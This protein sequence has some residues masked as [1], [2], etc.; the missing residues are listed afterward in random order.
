MCNPIDPPAKEKSCIHLKRRF[1]MK[2]WIKALFLVAMV[3]SVVSAHAGIRCG[4]DLIAVGETSFEVQI[5]LESCGSVIA[6]KQ[7]G[8]S[9]ET[10]KKGD[11]DV[12]KERLVERWYIRVNERGGTYCY[13]LI[14]EQGL[15]NEI[16]N[17]RQC[18]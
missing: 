9:T 3:L 16:G 5:K 14:F 8:K 10:K 6:K 13:P 12:E 7:V 17:W 11:T 2:P 15:L 18:D 4:D 1:V